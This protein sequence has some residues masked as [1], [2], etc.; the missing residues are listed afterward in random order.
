MDVAGPQDVLQFEQYHLRPDERGI[1]ADELPECYKKLTKVKRLGMPM[2]F[3]AWSALHR[4]YITT[5]LT[6]SHLPE[7]IEYLK[8]YGFAQCDLV[9]GGWKALSP[10]D[11]PQVLADLKI[12][13]TEKTG[14][15]SQLQV[16][17]CT[18]LVFQQR[19]ADVVLATKRFAEKLGV[20]WV[21]DC[22]LE[23]FIIHDVH[24][25]D[26]LYEEYFD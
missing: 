17:D 18:H 26:G 2:I 25:G 5:R 13:L 7:S 16:I 3:H 4:Q 8:L 12:I 20:K 15:L 24:F 19:H 23:N 10:D 14:Q 6:P 11:L 21:F 22:S 9:E 1:E